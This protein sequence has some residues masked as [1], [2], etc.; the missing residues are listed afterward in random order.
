MKIYRIRTLNTF[1]VPKSAQ[2]FNF[3]NFNFRATYLIFTLNTTYSSMYQAN[4]KICRKSV[5]SNHF[6]N[7]FIFFKSQG[8]KI[9]Q[10]SL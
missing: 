6:H 10:F 9:P 5:I 3:E 1:R 8:L 7:W 4:T 2:K